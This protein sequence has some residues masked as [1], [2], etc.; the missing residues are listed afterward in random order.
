M[1]LLF[2]G[3]WELDDG[4]LVWLGYGVEV[5]WVKVRGGEWWWRSELGS[6]VGLRCGQVVGGCGVKL[7]YGF[8]GGVG[9]RVTFE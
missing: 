4:E 9:L 7:K 3:G 2:E 6:G 5:S 1:V 8:G